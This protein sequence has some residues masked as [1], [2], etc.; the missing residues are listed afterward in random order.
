MIYS[1]YIGW[2]KTKH[3]QRKTNSCCPK[4]SLD[5]PKRLCMKY[6]QVTTACPTCL[7]AHLGSWNA[8]WCL[9]QLSCFWEFHI[10]GKTH[11]T[12]LRKRN[13]FHSAFLA[14]NQFTALMGSVA[15]HVGLVQPVTGHSAIRYRPIQSGYL[16]SARVIWSRR[17]TLLPR[18]LNSADPPLKST[19]SPPPRSI[20]A[21]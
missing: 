16:S 5:A 8:F 1:K 4:N 21:C 20:T 10:Y 6:S 11:Q 9:A 13:M 12:I 2:N 17:L 7:V 15:T 18:E 3:L 14:R 19:S